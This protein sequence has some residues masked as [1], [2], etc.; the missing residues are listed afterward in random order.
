MNEYKKSVYIDLLIRARA[1]DMKTLGAL[2]ENERLGLLRIT[3]QVSGKLFK[4]RASHRDFVQ[5][6]IM[7]A[8]ES[9]D[10]FQGLTQL[11]FRSWLLEILKNVLVSQYRYHYL[12]QKRSLHLE[13]QI[14][15]EL[16]ETSFLLGWTITDS[17]PSWKAIQNEQDQKLHEALSTLQ[18]EVRETI[19]LR[20]FQNLSFQKIAEIQHCTS[21]A[22][23]KRY[24]R[25]II[26]LGQ[27]LRKIQ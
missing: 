13:K 2:I 15:Q 10:S 3:A 25:G 21:K 16:N 20:E 8:L 11:E 26:Q 5:D 12:A 19:I 7:R 1:G 17:T 6:S 23:Q 9:F 14:G 4:S 18:R 27:T 24:T 22:A